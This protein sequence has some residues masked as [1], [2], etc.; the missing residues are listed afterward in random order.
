NETTINRKQMDCEDQGLIVQAWSKEGK[1]ADKSFDK[2]TEGL[3]GIWSF[4]K[5]ILISDWRLGQGFT[6]SIWVGRG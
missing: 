2:L 4:W 1:R 6:I 5:R 3:E